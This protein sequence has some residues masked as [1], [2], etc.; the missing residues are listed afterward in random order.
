M[1]DT[2]EPG[3]KPGT[4]YFNEKTGQVFTLYKDSTASVQG[5]GA[6]G[7]KN[8]PSIN[9]F[10]PE[11]AV[12]WL[13]KHPQNGNV[14]TDQEKVSVKTLAA[15]YGVDC[16]EATLGQNVVKYL[17]IKDKAGDTL[18]TLRKMKGS[19]H[20]MKSNP[21]ETVVVTTEWGILWNKLDEALKAW[22]AAN[23]QPTPSKNPSELSPLETLAVE[24][25]AKKYGLKVKTI[26]PEGLIGYLG[27]FTSW[28]SSVWGIQKFEGMYR[29]LNTINP[30]DWSIIDQYAYFQE[31]LKK[32]N[33]LADNIFGSGQ[34]KLS[35]TQVSEIMKVATD[36]NYHTNQKLMGMMPNG[37][38]VYWL[39]L[40]DPQGVVQWMV[41]KDKGSYIIYRV[42]PG[43]L[44]WDKWTDT[45]S[46][47]EMLNKL[48]LYLINLK[49]G[50]PEA[51]KEHNGITPEEYNQ[52]RDAVDSYGDNFKTQYNKGTPGQGPF[53]VILEKEFEGK[54]N[55]YLTIGAL[56]NYYQINNVSGKPVFNTGTI[57]EILKWIHEKLTSIVGEAASIS[58]GDLADITHLLT[59][60]KFDYATPGGGTNEYIYIKEKDEVRINIK[61]FVT[62][63]RKRVFGPIRHKPSKVF[64]N[65][66]VNVY[67]KGELPPDGHELSARIINGLSKEGFV[68]KD[69]GQ[70][71][72]HQ[73]INAIKWLRGYLM[74]LT[75]GEVGLAKSKWA[76]ENLEQFLA[77]IVLHGLP[78]M[79]IHGPDSSELFNN[80]PAA[81]T[82]PNIGGADLEL[83]GEEHKEIAE[84][85]GTYAPTIKFQ[86]PN[87]NSM[88]MWVGANVT[89]Y[90]IDKV[91]GTYRVYND[92][93]NQ[94]QEVYYTGSF[95]D[96]KKFLDGLC[97][98]LINILKN[99]K[100]GILDKVP[101][102]T[103][104]ENPDKLSLSEVKT[105]KELVKAFN[106]SIGTY[107]KKIQEAKENE[108][109]HVI[110]SDPG[111]SM[112]FR[113][114]KKAGKYHFEK[115]S[116][117][118][119]QY[120]AVKIFDQFYQLLYYVDF[121]INGYST[122]EISPEDKAK[123]NIPILSKDQYEWVE[124]F[125]KKHA[126]G[127]FFK[128]FN[129]G[130]VG[131]YDTSHK[132][133]GSDIGNP[134]FVIRPSPSKPGGII[135]QVHT[136]DNGMGAEEYPFDDFQSMSEW[137]IDNVAVMTQLMKGG[138]IEAKLAGLM[139]K[140][141]FVYQN[142]SAVMKSEGG[143][144]AAH[145]YDN[146]T[147]DRIYLFDD[148]SSKVWK[149]G[150]TDS[151]EYKFKT[152][153]ELVAFLEDPTKATPVGVPDKSELEQIQE[154]LAYLGFATPDPKGHSQIWLRIGEVKEKDYVHLHTDG[155]S[156]VTP[157]PMIADLSKPSSAF[158]FNTFQALKAYL[159]EKYIKK[160]NF[161]DAYF[162]T[163]LKKGGFKKKDDPDAELGYV[164]WHKKL[165]VVP[166]SSGGTMFTNVGIEPKIS[167]SFESTYDLARR[168]E[169]WIEGDTDYQDPGWSTGDGQL[170]EFIDDIGFH[171]SGHEDEEG[172]GQALIFMHEEGFKLKFHTADQSS[173]VTFP[174][175]PKIHDKY[176]TT[177]SFEGYQELK[178]YLQ[179]AI[180]MKA[181][182]K[183]L[184]QPEAQK[185]TSTELLKQSELSYDKDAIDLVTHD[186]KYLVPGM[187]ESIHFQHAGIGGTG[188]VRALKKNELLFAIG[189][190]K[191]GNDLLWYIRQK[192]SDSPSG[193]YLEYSFLTKDAM[194]DWIKAHADPLCSWKSVKGDDGYNL[195][196][197]MQPEITPLMHPTPSD[198]AAQIAAAGKLPPQT[199]KVPGPQYYP[200][201]D[202]VALL[203]SKGFKG[204]IKPT[205]TTWVH[206]SK[207]HFTL[208][209]N[210]IVWHYEHGIKELYVPMDNQ[211]EFLKKAL[212]HAT[213]E[214]NDS[215]LDF[216]FSTMAS[217]R[218]QKLFDKAVK[219]AENSNP[220]DYAFNH[221]HKRME[222]KGFDFDEGSKIWWNDELYQVVAPIPPEDGSGT[223]FK[224][225][226][227][228]NGGIQSAIHISEPSLFQHIGMDGVY[229]KVSV[230]V[231]P[232]KKKEDPYKPSGETY[233][234][235]DNESNADL[236]WLNQHDEE[237][238]SAMGFYRA[239]QE[240]RYYKNNLG[241]II[242]FRNTGKAAFFEYAGGD[243]LYESFDFES[244]PHA[245]KFIVLKYTTGPW[246]SEDYNTNIDPD[247]ITEIKLNNH[248]TYMLAQLGFQWNEKEKK[249]YKFY[250]GED[251]PKL[252]Q[253]FDIKPGDDVAEAKKKKKQNP[254]PNQPELGLNNPDAPNDYHEILTC[255][256]TGKAIW[257]LMQEDGHQGGEKEIFEETIPHMLQFL[258]MRW[259]HQL[260]VSLIG[261]KAPQP[262]AATPTA[263]DFDSFPGIQMP[264]NIHEKFL[265]N[266]FEY[267]SKEKEYVKDNDPG[268]ATF[269]WTLVKYDG[270]NY[271]VSYPQKSQDKNSEAYKKGLAVGKKEFTTSD[272]YYALNT[273][274]KVE[275]ADF[276]MIVQSE[277]D[278]LKVK[279]S[280]YFNAP[281]GW[282][283]YNPYAPVKHPGNI[284]PDTWID[285]ELEAYGFAW[286]DA[287]DMYW[288]TPATDDPNIKAL[289]WE[290]VR[291]DKNGTIVYFYPGGIGTKGER[292]WFASKDFA[293]VEQKIEIN[294]GSA[295]HGELHPSQVGMVPQQP[296][297][298]SGKILD[299]ANYPK[300]PDLMKDYSVSGKAIKMVDQDHSAVLAAG[301]MF[302]PK[303]ITYKNPTNKDSFR[304]FSTGMVWY[305]LTGTGEGISNDIGHFF[306]MLKSKYGLL[307]W[308]DQPLSGHELVFYKDKLEKIGFTQVKGLSE[309]NFT[310]ERV[311]T[312][313]KTTMHVVEQ[314]ILYPNHH[315]TFYLN[316]KANGVMIGNYD[317]ESAK[318]GIQTLENGGSGGIA[319]E[320]A[321]ELNST[322]NQRGFVHNVKS[323][324]YES[325]MKVDGQDITLT[326]YGDGIAWMHA[327]KPIGGGEVDITAE[328]KF[329]NFFNAIAWAADKN[330]Q[331][332]G[333]VPIVATPVD[334]ETVDK[335]MD[336]MNLEADGK[337]VLGKK[338]KN[339]DGSK[340]L[341][342][343]LGS[344]KVVYD[345]EY[346]S[347]PAT[348]E[349]K[350]GQSIFKDW[351][352]FSDWAMAV[353]MSKSKKKPQKGKLGYTPHPAMK[354]MP[355]LPAPMPFS[356]FDYENW[357]SG[358]GY[359]SNASIAL[360]PEDEKT[361]LK[362]G[363]QRQEKDGVIFYKNSKGH[364][365]YFFVN[366]EA[367]L[368]T[369]T[370]KHF[371]SI[372]TLLDTL[373]AESMHS[374]WPSTP[375]LEPQN[376]PVLKQTSEA[377]DVDKELSSMGFQFKQE[378]I[379]GDKTYW[380]KSGGDVY[381]VIWHHNDNTL[382][383]VWGQK[384]KTGDMKVVEHWTLDTLDAIAK[385]H[386]G[387]DA[388]AKVSHKGKKKKPKVLAGTEDMPWSDIDYKKHWVFQAS[389]V[390]LPLEYTDDQ[391]MKKM[392][393]KDVPFGDH[394]VAYEKENQRMAFYRNGSTVYW[395]DK[396]SSPTQNW[397]DPEQAVRWLWKNWKEHSQKPAQEQV[398]AVLKHL[399]FEKIPVATTT[400]SGE[401]KN[402]WGW[403]LTDKDG[404][405]DVTFDV[406]NNTLKWSLLPSATS[407]LSISSTIFDTIQK[408]L[409][410]L[411]SAIKKTPLAKSK[412]EGEVPYSGTDYKQWWKTYWPE[413]VPH[414][415]ISL[416]PEDTEV[417]EKIGF[418]K[419]LHKTEKSPEFQVSYRNNHNEVLYFFAGGEAAY[420]ANG[421]GPKYYGNAK[422]LMQAM[423]DK[424]ADTY[425]AKNPTA[426]VTGQV[427]FSGTDYANEFKD[428]SK[429]ITHHL[430]NDHSVM[431]KMGFTPKIGQAAD[432]VQT[433]Y[434]V[435]PKTKEQVY[436]FSD[437][438]GMVMGEK[439]PTDI[440]NFN[441]VKETLQYLWDEHMPHI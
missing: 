118:G 89:S 241:D 120:E 268:N 414:Q 174:P 198:A 186:L 256:D 402:G 269:M 308:G 437:G 145:I 3:T 191:V 426:K 13:E 415:A 4:K 70:V 24:D 252:H 384:N 289:Q 184:E 316:D 107:Q 236:I 205:G 225:W 288:Y 106:L 420:W 28:G 393:W 193:L 52:I 92:M 301:F 129:N 101:S 388:I 350:W 188:E 15:S 342:V 157:S 318:Y 33:E 273:I 100:M 49:K 133:P 427:P 25:V 148:G 76:I 16:D 397:P 189:K 226:W 242:K 113:I 9:F 264:P 228:S 103:P 142:T 403:R 332:L 413:T 382:E 221:F 352:E 321:P 63:T 74:D 243:K 295:H 232:T 290:A 45:A 150:Q 378:N 326:F 85:L 204:E 212:T 206:P 122:G 325:S 380:K 143:T 299:A 108:Y 1:M 294:H 14:L 208:H 314:V 154:Y 65:W 54:H 111:H 87:D 230:K 281:N 387:F 376:P 322:M 10:S 61:N 405:S 341:L 343:N 17:V 412:T 441:T 424:Y 35:D 178:D 80:I 364:Y 166:F 125:V 162:K 99:S 179:K 197:P 194:V 246:A 149:K 266:G 104:A 55:L 425:G 330:L 365:I 434:Y 278:A 432:G 234:T 337:G 227:I 324:R 42:F 347:N 64:I 338:Y 153:G 183:S 156:K 416:K 158:F 391:T 379:D 251:T 298:N 176:P 155:E 216:M 317:F 84:I 144:K 373:W 97:G 43:S 319:L 296:K 429:D 20:L 418:T 320:L 94:W 409:N 29:V 5:P 152:I 366:G 438:H 400:S 177:I 292:R 68:N 18:F 69:S 375:E 98:N 363:F 170:D 93:A 57:T 315:L 271:L 109:A 161:H 201:E 175:D 369:T 46:Y 187:A 336:A 37:H 328:K 297:G 138:A 272:P 119:S 140:W 209:T 276:G 249:Y 200:E 213:P 123:Y 169:L 329:D 115:T 207:F 410:A 40:I 345:F 277:D 367:D 312:D 304:I 368:H 284:T 135:V 39:E 116:E 31:A 172:G 88:V 180:A 279:D 401:S 214:N 354:E 253:Q 394:G 47:E 261:K 333:D 282:T 190:K 50:P 77:Y 124:T 41:G 130:V 141:G 34:G 346:V 147:N 411:I 139:E 2:T 423:W 436:F 126:P 274:K 137:I 159:T 110:I 404:I 280:N 219:M 96:L 51:P 229:E 244:I 7:V 360:V 222:D 323:G 306:D 250:S 72:P 309:K 163:V 259:S 95:Q 385:L 12:G 307:E 383:F 32:L 408:G 136:K 255:Y 395:S 396:T 195:G 78:A 224:V 245:L 86:I 164:F 262:P 75:G 335:L 372:K 353:D 105:L 247:A 146:H 431:M 81:L 334:E 26:A 381:E 239:P 371:T 377:T 90:K 258:W 182:G 407:G 121:Y 233:K 215:E 406:E 83:T 358:K 362:L 38:V 30:K 151:A 248:D 291:F 218:E 127:V 327:M 433:A 361:M 79:D 134:L 160:K 300:A 356:G 348:G 117:F 44:T 435:H 275:N 386:E 114:Y 23:P 53:A 196:T 36:N 60:A 283:P 286:A 260:K 240:N 58:S 417:L 419:E 302:F 238:L 305:Q 167:F 48:S 285:K 421:E 171:Y 439:T 11:D 22:S 370:T 203:K 27:I 263:M 220:M 235:Q 202:I 185:M 199:P 237:I 392:G 192:V 389:D 165:T 71:M 374:G 231:T 217:S 62:F 112:W 82:S 440:K 91:S 59:D 210:A 399:G 66:F 311:P 359:N 6:Q 73:K 310:F 168:I 422:N 265:T 428:F 21:A 430:T 131:G 390:G 331:A 8:A 344:G 19:Y 102:A 181:Q 355:V 267:D 357:A 398:E 67:M 313:K 211:G 132:V 56:G 173:S 340:R 223:V 349:V 303:E 293:E 257:Q 270:T 351:K 254:D 287:S 128:Q 339:G